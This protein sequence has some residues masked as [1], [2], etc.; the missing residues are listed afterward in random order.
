M[1]RLGLLPFALAARGQGVD[2]G[3]HQGVSRMRL[4][5][6]AV[7]IARHAD[8]PALGAERFDPHQL[9]VHPDPSHVLARVPGQFARDGGGPQRDAPGG[10]GLEFERRRA[11]VER[12]PQPRAGMVKKPAAHL[13]FRHGGADGGHGGKVDELEPRVQLAHLGQ[14]LPAQGLAED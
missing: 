14:N 2:G 13:L 11:G 8:L 6:L 9:I 12:R 10:I 3:E 4:G 1:E 5:G 7:E